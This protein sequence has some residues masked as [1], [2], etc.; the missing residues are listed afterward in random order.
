M[1]LAGAIKPRQ[2]A[3][4]DT[5]MT[6]KTQAEQA[7]TDVRMAI[8]DHMA[9]RKLE[10]DDV[11]AGI[12]DGFITPAELA[13]AANWYAWSYQGSFSYMLDMQAACKRYGRLTNGQIKGVLNCLRA[14]ALREA[15]QARAAAAMA[16]ASPELA[17][18]AESLQAPQAAAKQIEGSGA[19]IANGIYTVRFEN[20]DYRTIKIT[21]GWAALEEGMQVAKFLSGSDNESSYQGFAFIQGS[22]AQVWRRFAEH[23]GLSLAL[24]ILMGSKE[25]QLAAGAAYA[26]SSGRCFICNRTLTTPASLDLGIGP[27][28][29]EK[30]GI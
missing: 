11:F 30:M 12:P 2:L 14:E 3:K 5:E 18:L 10:L 7:L 27:N 29:A 25:A 19:E 9:D 17:A 24:G 23:E 6:T 4:R 21:K 15:A 22:K 8:L 20:G 16:P 13:I 1:L 28:C 26:Q